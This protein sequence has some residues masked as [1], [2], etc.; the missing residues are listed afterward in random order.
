MF[1]GVAK[2][3]EKAPIPSSSHVVMQYL[4]TQGYFNICYFWEKKKK[5]LSQTPK[6]KSEGRAEEEQGQRRDFGR[7]APEDDA[8]KGLY[9]RGQ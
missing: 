4:Q 3:R 9:P 2:G 7:R 1:Y 8:V 6:H 5:Q